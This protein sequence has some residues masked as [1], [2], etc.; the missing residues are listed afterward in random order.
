MPS[1]GKLNL[2]AGSIASVAAAVAIGLAIERLLYYVSQA[3]VQFVVV[4]VHPPGFQGSVL[5]FGP[6]PVGAVYFTYKGYT[7]DLSFVCT[8]ALSLVLLGTVIYLFLFRWPDNPLTRRFAAPA[9]E[10]EG[11]R[12]CP[13]CFSEI[14]EEATRC[15]F[16]TSQ[17]SQAHS[18]FP[19]PD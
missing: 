18:P 5:S 7:I 2:N 10:V 16:C 12:E 8:A 1:S 4:L 15:P 17:L 13:Y 3:I 19:A 11:G 14:V 6:V 9:E